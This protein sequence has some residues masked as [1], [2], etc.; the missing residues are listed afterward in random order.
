MR[1][2]VSGRST[3]LFL[4]LLSWAIAPVHGAEPA[5]LGD[6]E[7]VLQR[8]LEFERARSWSAAI[9]LYDKA[10]EQ[11]PSRTDLSHRR[12]LCETHYRLV[13][14]YQDQS[15]RNVL[16]KLPRERALGLFEEL[17]E[18]IESHY[19]DP[20]PLE[21]LV[22]KGLDNLEVALRDPNFL[23]TNASQATPERVTWLRDA[24]RRQRARLIVPDRAAAQAHVLAACD[25]ARKAISCND[26]P[27]ILEFTYGAC[28]ALDDYTSYLTPDKLDDLYAMIDGNFVGLGVELK[29]DPEGLKIVA[30]IRGGPAS[31]SGMIGGDLI[32]H[33]SGAPVKGLSLDEAANRLQGTE[34]SKV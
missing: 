31:D 9:D 34:G 2:L 29:Q 11:W 6:P 26:A 3:W 14:R 20:V 4:A 21:P 33:I 13:R 8:A 32:T 30:V 22:R 27:I 25:L 10:L 12:R 7:T 16:L 1:T 23:R 19:V 28:D 18:R 24:L 17:I 15:F 5:D